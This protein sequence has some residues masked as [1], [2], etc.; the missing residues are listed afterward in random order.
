MGE[1]N[2]MLIDFTQSKVP[3]GMGFLNQNNPVI[4]K[5]TGMR[6][7]I[8]ILTIAL[9]T[10]S[11]HSCGQQ[12][13]DGTLHSTHWSPDSTL[14]LEVYKEKLTMALPGQGGDHSAIIVLKKNDGEILHIVDGN[15][16]NQILLRGFQGVHWEMERNILTYA[17]ARKIEWVDEENIDMGI[18]LEKISSHLGYDSWEFYR[19]PE[20]YG[21]R[22]YRIGEFFG[23]PEYDYTLDMAILIKDSLEVVKLL[24]YE[25]FNYNHPYDGITF[26]DLKEDYTW[27]GNFKV[28][29]Q[30]SPIWSNWEEGKGEDGRREFKDVPENEIIHLNRDALFLHAGESC[31]GGFIYWE[32][33]KWNWKQQE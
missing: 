5:N 7:Y 2:W 1:S 12:N 30:G 17:P 27:V 26:I 8:K 24:M 14:C 21:D 31:G 16:M 15:S 10:I 29:K 4:L 25:A 28:V 3:G 22:Y 32:N 18:I 33:D 6:P 11:M 13:I 19:T 20:S 23:D 9:I